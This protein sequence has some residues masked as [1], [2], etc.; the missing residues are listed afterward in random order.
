LPSGTNGVLSTSDSSYL[1]AYGTA[2]GW[3]FAT[4]IGTVNAANLANNWPGAATT[5]T[6][7][8]SSN[9]AYQ[10][11]PVTF[12]AT[13]ATVG[14]HAPTGTVNFNDGATTIGNGTLSTV[15]GSQ[16]ATYTTSTLAVGAHSITAVY[17]GDS[18]NAGSTSSVLT[19]TINVAPTF[20][21]VSTGSASHTVLAGQQSLTY[22]FKA[23][24]TSGATFVNAVNIACSFSPAD[25]TLTSSIC[26]Y[27]VNGGAPQSG[28]ATIPAGSGTSTVTVTAT[29]AGPNSGTGSQLRHRSDNRLPWLPLT[30]PLAGVVMVGFAGRKMS[31]A[32]TVAGMCL[33]LALAGFLVACGSS[34]PPISIASVTGSSAS[35]YPQNVGWTN[36]TATFT[37]TLNNDSGNKG[38]TWS[39]SPTF[40][41]QSI[42]ATDATHATYTPPTIAA[43]L[44]SPITVTATSVADTSKTGNASIAL[45]PTTVPINGGYTI[46]V[47]ASEAGATS[48]GANVT[49]VVN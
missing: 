22:T 45:N 35:I 18:N 23:T 29:T 13:V 17:V 11:A 3:D 49:L 42:T 6:V 36:S 25:P 46:T 43:G 24:P 39:V 19:Q 40:S 2:T 4:G 26:S 10:G 41:G 12:T 38:V 37:A 7:T 28:S 33:M 32:A 34:T 1:P 14:G 48:Q 16:V 9:P 44:T 15:T 5:T 20:T 21:F 27:S 31:R 8:S 30:L 47:T